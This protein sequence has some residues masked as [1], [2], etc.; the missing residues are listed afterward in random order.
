M[1]FLPHDAVRLSAQYLLLKG[2]KGVCPSIRLSVRHN[3]VLCQKSFTYGR[4]DLCYAHC[5]VAV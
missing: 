5:S 4:T 1:V 3:L 2:Q